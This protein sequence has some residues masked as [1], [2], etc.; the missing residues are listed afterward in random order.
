MFRETENVKR[1]PFALMAPDGLGLELQQDFG[2]RDVILC[3]K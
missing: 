1:D 2:F 3:R